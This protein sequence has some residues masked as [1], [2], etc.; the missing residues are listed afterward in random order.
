MA[1]IKD[2]VFTYLKKWTDVDVKPLKTQ[3]KQYKNE[4][5]CFQKQS[6][7]ELNRMILSDGVKAVD[8]I[9][10]LTFQ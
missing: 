4:K 2:N 8:E 9:K 7:C 1:G 3:C 10:Y 6:L 5:L